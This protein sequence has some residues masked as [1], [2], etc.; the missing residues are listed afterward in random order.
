MV[1]EDDSIEDLL[2]CPFC[3]AGTTQIYINRHP[4][5]QINVVREPISYE[6][7]HWCANVM[8]GSITFAGRDRK[9]VVAYWNTRGPSSI[10]RA[11]PLQG[12]G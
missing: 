3:K 12:R 8:R 2:P 1:E 4:G 11:L 6:I 9:T 10:G 5:V 7:R